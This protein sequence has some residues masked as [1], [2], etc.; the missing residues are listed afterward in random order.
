MLALVNGREWCLNEIHIK[1]FLSTRRIKNV[2]EHGRYNE[3]TLS[4]EGLHDESSQCQ[5]M[6]VNCSF[7]ISIVG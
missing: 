1:V 4:I 2:L 6:A 7:L 5:F 3:M